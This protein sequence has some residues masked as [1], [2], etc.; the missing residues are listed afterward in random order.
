MGIR[1]FFLDTSRVKNLL[2]ILIVAT[3]P[4]QIN[5]GNAALI[6]AVLFNLFFYEKKHLQKI[7]SFSVIF[8]ISFFLI[9]AISGLLSNDYLKGVAQLDRQLLLLLI[10]II[11]TNI[12]LKKEVVD[13]VIKFFFLT[14]AIGTF[15]L[16]L[17]MI[18]KVSSGISLES[19]IF[20]N[21][22]SLYDQHPV[23]YS[24]YL[25]LCL[26]YGLDKLSQAEKINKRVIIMG[27]I[28]LVFGLIFC[29][30]KAVIFIDILL[31]TF[32]ILYKIN[33]IK[34]KIL[35]SIL[36]ISVMYGV[37]NVSFVKERF[38]DGL[39]FDHEIA[40]FQPSNHFGKKKSFTY[41]EKTEISDLE[42]RILFLKIGT[43][44]LIKDN[45]LF[46]GYGQG[47]VQDYIDYHLI[48]YNLGP[49]WFEG[50]NVHNQ[51]LHYVLNY[52][53]F[54][55]IFFLAYLAYSFNSAIRNKDQLHIFFL[56]SMC[57]VFLFEVSLLRNKGLIFFYF[58][59]TLFLLKHYQFENRNIR[60]SWNT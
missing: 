1:K 7:K 37:V 50:F 2:L 29:A 56:L 59:N 10:V 52:G 49:N 48:T 53:I 11:L 25:S 31:I 20:H 40:S 14:T 8:P 39:T 30:S 22:T 15:V 24:L 38:L 46:F 34:K 27:L 47:D 57:F 32:L 9:S 58:F 55:L 23:Y 13:K 44:H 5:L 42:L 33:H 19:L 17:N 41:D 6:L 43:Y 4:F 16:L 51:Y 35:Y 54:V 26:F 36:F 18:I 3:I 28:L 45:K 21:F 60:N 12:E